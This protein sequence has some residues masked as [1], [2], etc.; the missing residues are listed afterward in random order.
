METKTAGK[1]VIRVRTLIIFQQLRKNIKKHRKR[2]L[3]R[4]ILQSEGC[5]YSLGYSKKISS[6]HN[7]GTLLK[8]GFQFATSYLLTRAN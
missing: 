8:L 1:V 4:K 2:A 7:S 6:Q 5:R 3:M